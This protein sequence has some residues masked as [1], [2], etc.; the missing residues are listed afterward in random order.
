M[1]V[2]SHAPHSTLVKSIVMSPFASG[3]TTNSLVGPEG[4]LEPSFFL[5]TTVNSSF[6]EFVKFFTF[7]WSC[8]HSLRS[9]PTAL[10]F[11]SLAAINVHA[12][13]Q[14]PD[15]QD[16]VFVSAFH[17]AAQYSSHLNVKYFFSALTPMH[18]T[19]SIKVSIH[20]VNT[21]III[22]FRLINKL[23]KFDKY[24]HK[25]T[26]KKRISTNFFVFLSFFCIF[27]ARNPK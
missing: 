15:P 25:N 6:C 21:L 22:N 13:F 23:Y 3:E 14:P 4:G 8:S 7:R 5:K 26:K 2:M 11:S 1:F 27:V 16:K 17:L 20:L 10:P 19:S 9:P 18:T 12:E 24:G